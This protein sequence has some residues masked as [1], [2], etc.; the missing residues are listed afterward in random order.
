MIL[1]EHCTIF[2]LYL[3][4]CEMETW[5]RS[6]AYSHTRT[7]TKIQ[8][9]KYLH[10]GNDLTKWNV[11]SYVISLFLFIFLISLYF[12]NYWNNGCSFWEFSSVPKKGKPAFIQLPLTLHIY[13]TPHLEARVSRPG[14]WKLP[15]THTYRFTKTTSSP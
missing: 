3:V 2:S 7:H 14:G 4:L 11:R 13:A 15:A 9:R 1:R 6:V 12:D 5:K 8:M 10:S